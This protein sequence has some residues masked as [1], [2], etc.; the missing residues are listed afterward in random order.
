M[1]TQTIIETVVT[2]HEKKMVTNTRLR[3]VIRHNLTDEKISDPPK[4]DGS[5]INGIC[6]KCGR[7]LKRS[8]IHTDV[9]IRDEN[10]NRYVI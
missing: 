4:C 1:A 9:A 10:G 6:V 7:Q 2:D 5:L 8:R 3:K